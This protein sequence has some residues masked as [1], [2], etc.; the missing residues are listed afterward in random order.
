MSKKQ[1]GNFMMGTILVIIGAFLLWLLRWFVLILGILVVAFFVRKYLKRREKYSRGEVYSIE[2]ACP[3][4]TRMNTFH[5][6]L[7]STQGNVTIKC[8]YCHRDYTR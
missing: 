3:N 4:C 8:H 6:P 7:G 1:Q 5:Y 2:H